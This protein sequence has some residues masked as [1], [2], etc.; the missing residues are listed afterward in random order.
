MPCLGSRQ[1]LPYSHVGTLRCN[2]NSS[3]LTLL[4]VDLL[5]TRMQQ[6]DG[7]AEVPKS[8]IN[9]LRRYPTIFHQDL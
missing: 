1:A 4:E 9:L 5:K 8:V 3:K 2:I 6:G 7:R